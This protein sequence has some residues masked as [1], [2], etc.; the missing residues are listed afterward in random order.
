MVSLAALF[1]LL[2]CSAAALRVPMMYACVCVY[3]CKI[4]S[5]L[6]AAKERRKKEREST[7]SVSTQRPKTLQEHLQVQYSAA[8]VYNFTRTHFH[9]D[10]HTHTHT[11]THTHHAGQTHKHKDTSFSLCISSTF[12]SSASF[13]SFSFWLRSLS[14]CGQVSVN[15]PH[16][17]LS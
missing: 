12:C 11:H 8:L 17:L 14:V 1:P 2:L 13:S 6:A 7:L 15:T 5:M 10:I 9:S 3:I 4:I 16:R